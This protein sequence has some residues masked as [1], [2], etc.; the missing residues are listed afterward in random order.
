MSHVALG[1][2]GHH[3]AAWLSPWL[4][5]PWSRQYLLVQNLGPHV[6]KDIT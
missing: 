6:K 3:C 2:P 5:R 1:N 4:I